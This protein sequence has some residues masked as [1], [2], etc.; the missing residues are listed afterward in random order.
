VRINIKVIFEHKYFVLN[1]NRSPTFYI[2]VV[3]FTRL[4]D[5]RLSD[6]RIYVR[7]ILWHTNT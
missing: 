7:C 5:K 3:P 6:Y 1:K 2:P 4:C